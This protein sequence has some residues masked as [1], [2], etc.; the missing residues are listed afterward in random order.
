MHNA[1]SKLLKDVHV[2]NNEYVGKPAKRK[3]FR[4][5]HFFLHQNSTLK[6]FLYE[7]YLK[8]LDFKI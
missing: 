3:I 6:L 1:P 7:L 5:S 2:A 8:R 4:L